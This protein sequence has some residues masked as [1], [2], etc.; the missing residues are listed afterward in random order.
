MKKMKDVQ[1]VNNPFTLVSFLLYFVRSFL[2]KFEPVERNLHNQLD[3][4]MCGPLLIVVEIRVFPFISVR[5]TDRLGNLS[6]MFQ[7]SHNDSRT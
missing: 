5:Y 7:I 6:A 4:P 2:P 1:L 3:G